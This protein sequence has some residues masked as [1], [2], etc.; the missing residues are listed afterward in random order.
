MHTH[1]QRCACC[2]ARGVPYRWF[3]IPLLLVLIGP[4]R[5][6]YCGTRSLRFFGLAWGRGG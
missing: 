4:Y 5:C 2:E 6:G 3:E 1:C